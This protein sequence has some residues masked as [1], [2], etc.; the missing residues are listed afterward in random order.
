MEDWSS[1]RSWMVRL[2]GSKVG[3]GSV[4][5]G[6]GFG[7]GGKRKGGKEKG[8]GGKVPSRSCSSIGAIFGEGVIIVIKGVEIWSKKRG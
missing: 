2:M 3:G 5:D 8:G 1:Y 7:R 4:A 6:R